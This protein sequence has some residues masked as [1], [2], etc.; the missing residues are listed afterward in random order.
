MEGTRTMIDRILSKALAGDTLDDQELTALLTCDRPDEVEKLYA[1]ARTVRQ[2]QFGSR[3]YLYGFVYF[4]TYCKNNCAFCYYRR[5]NEHPKRY[6]KTVDEI[7]GT[8][9][10]LQRSGV[11]LIDLTMG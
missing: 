7:V 2:R 3:V 10:E 6:R 1:A 5:D 9:A 11:H 8:A 4:S